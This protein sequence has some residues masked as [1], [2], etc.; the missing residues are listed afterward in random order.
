V[1]YHLPTCFVCSKK[2]INNDKNA[3]AF[4]CAS[5]FC[6]YNSFLYIN[7]WLCAVEQAGWY[8]G[9]RQSSL[10]LGV[11]PKKST[12]VDL[13]VA[14]R[15]ESIG[16]VHK[17]SLLKLICT[18]RRKLTLNAN[19]SQNLHIRSLLFTWFH[20]KRNSINYIYNIFPRHKTVLLDNDRVVVV[21]EVVVVIVTLA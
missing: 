4:S 14:S 8:S 9:T 13:G 3:C 10:D 7:F 5:H 19:Y 18:S 11:D 20:I 12:G 6:S 17:K 1:V 2:L 16:F 15:V 21:V